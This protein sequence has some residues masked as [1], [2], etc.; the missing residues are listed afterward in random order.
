MIALCIWTSLR[1]NVPS[2]PRSSHWALEYWDKAK[3][4][5]VALIAPEL[6]VLWSIRQW[7]AARKMAKG[8][9]EYGWTR[10]HV[11]FALMGGFAVYDSDGNS[12]FHLGDDQ[13][14]E[15]FKDEG[16]GW[17]ERGWDGLE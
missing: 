16:R 9:Q 4:F 17:D 13:F 14:C 10:T 11:S 12:L 6:I 1:P 5:F 15:H 2:I 7:F 8:Y 3:I